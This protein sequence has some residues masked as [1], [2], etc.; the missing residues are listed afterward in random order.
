MTPEPLPPAPDPRK[1]LDDYAPA[2]MALRV[3]AAVATKLSQPLHAVV[4]LSVLAGAFIAFGAMFYTLAVTGSGLGFG[5]ERI[6]GG[7]AFSLG[8][9]LVVVGGAELFT[10]NMLA[11]LAWVDG[12]ASFAAPARFWG[13]IYL[14][15]LIGALGSAVLVWL[16]GTLGLADHGLAATAI[17]IAAA[18]VAIPLDEAFFR[19]VLC[20]T[21]VCLA[22]W[23]CFAA[24]SV[25]SKVL[26]IAFP[27]TAF[28]AL[29]FEHSIANMYLIPIGW[30]AALDAGAVA[31]AGLTPAMLA[32]LDLG[33]FVSNLVP[34]T[35]GN[36]VG[37][38]VFVALVYYVVYRF[39]RGVT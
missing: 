22:V 24:R 5:P 34:V 37:G 32:D 17:G 30:L 38:G 20:N 27:I 14:G 29:G 23:L 3:E 7:L 31:E 26:A 21:L 19:G 2:E 11:L 16:S 28:V 13:V 35:L 39:R 33:G 12:R 1:A 15:N 8:L 4:M 9:V 10:G 6:L 25:G 36:I 18:K